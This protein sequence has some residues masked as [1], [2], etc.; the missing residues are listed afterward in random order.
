MAVIRE[1]QQF[2]NSRI[3]VVRMDTG[4]SQ[5]W[6]TVASAADSLTQQAFKQAS[7][8]AQNKGKEF[9]ESVG[10]ESLRTIDPATGKPQ[11]FK[12][13]TSFGTIAQAAYEETLDR[14][15]IRTVDREIR[16][17]A[18]ETY[19]KYEFDPQ[20]VEK[21][22]QV[23]EDYIGGMTKNADKR[24]EGIVRDTGAAYIAST[25]FN[26]MQK[27]NL[28]IK[29]AEQIAQRDDAKDN[30]SFIESMAENVNWSL[31]DSQ[32]HRDVEDMYME[33]VAGQ[34]AANVAGLISD[35]QFEANVGVMRRALPKAILSKMINF[36]AVYEK[37][38]G[39]TV[40]INSDVALSIENSLKTNRVLDEVPTALKPQVQRILDSEAYDK[41]R[42]N[43]ARHVTALRTNLSLKESDAVKLTAFQKTVLNVAEE[44]FVV[45]TNDSQ[46]K[47]AGDVL[48]ANEV[49]SLDPARPNM[50]PYFTS[51]ESTKEDA[52]WKIMVAGKGIIT[53]GMEL[54]L[55]RIYRLEGMTKEQIEIGLSHYDYLA[56]VNIAGSTVNK[57]L[58]TT[59]SNE[60][61]AFLRTLSYVTRV[62]GSENIVE[63][64]AK[65]KENMQNTSAVN[66]RVKS[67]LG[68]GDKD[69]KS[70]NDL[71][72][73]YLQGD[74][75]INELTAFGTDYQMVETVKPY[76]KHLIMSGVGKE[77]I[78]QQ[79]NEMFKTSYINTVGVVVDRYNSQIDKSMFALPRLL[80]DYAERQAFY[81]NATELV[82]TLSGKNFL[83]REK[84]QYIGIEKDRQIKLVPMTTSAFQPD[85]LPLEYK[86][87]DDLSEEGFVT[88]SSSLQT[89]QYI[90]HYV[91]DDGQL[92]MIPDKNGSPIFI[93]TELA[94]EDIANIRKAQSQ[95]EMYDANKKTL[96]K[97]EI[98]RQTKARIDRNV[99]ALSNIASPFKG[100]D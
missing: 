86:I 6:Q 96:R 18:N 51:E 38:D 74:N 79:L 42:D 21:Y 56:N 49:D 52:P 2:R 34:R 81:S 85:V 31:P 97:I 89:F 91:D 16:D 95:D 70:A 62:G 92:R 25:K 4:E 27:R 55:K 36:D 20:G 17:K 14:R 84:G 32:G 75:D 1:K 76:V 11:A 60:E 23:M 93:G 46:V 19:L 77:D 66:D 94:Y 43:I 28:R 99:E 5:M 44:G 15:Y 72:N 33:G 83:M 57:T 58:D 80:P 35:A 98:S 82:Q 71:L 26:L 64:A 54:T 29:E 73:A 61:N 90:A 67:V 3:G 78:N 40:Q 87:D 53:E 9:A 100:D 69:K 41:D 22:S 65:L 45:D 50:V 10:E 13:P 7:V 63:F 39:S 47:K 24:F 68:D 59:L 88:R 8:E 30:A 37:E 12:A 48:I